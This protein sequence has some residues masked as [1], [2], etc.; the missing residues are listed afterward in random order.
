M[1]TFFFG[2]DAKESLFKMLKSPYCIDRCKLV[3]MRSKASSHF[4]KQTWTFVGSYGI[5]MNDLDDSHFHSDSVGKSNVP[6]QRL[7]LTKSIGSAVRGELL[8][9]WNHFNY[10][11]VFI[12]NPNVDIFPLHLV[13]DFF[14]IWLGT[15]AMAS[16]QTQKK[17]VNENR[18]RIRD[19]NVPEFRRTVSSRAPSPDMKCP[20]QIIIF[21]GQDDRV[22]LS[23]KSCLDHRHH[24]PL[25]SEAILRGQNDMEQGDLDLLLLLFFGWSNWGSNFT[26]YAR[27]KG[28]WWW[29]N[30]SKTNLWHEPEDWGATWLGSWINTQLFRCSENNY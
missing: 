17:L 27:L 25:K 26:I 15:D 28:C 8:L 3:S 30:T 10:Q 23:T 21:L 13:I 2:I 5:V 7:K 4:R 24:P 1:T 22:Y 12:V 11:F 6:I 14:N 29:R 19:P 9:L 18:K 20:M 16:K